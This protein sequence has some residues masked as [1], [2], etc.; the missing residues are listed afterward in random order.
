M[1]K[2]VGHLIGRNARSDTETLHW[3]SDLPDL[4]WPEVT[5]AGR[6]A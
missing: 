4:R 2:L 1:D 3:E 6:Q 5:V